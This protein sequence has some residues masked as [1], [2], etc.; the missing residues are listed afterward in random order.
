MDHLDSYTGRQ[1]IVGNQLVDIGTI[2]LQQCFGLFDAPQKAVTHVQLFVLIDT[3]DAGTPVPLVH[4]CNISQVV[5]APATVHDLH[6]FQII[7]GFLPLL[8]L[9]LFF[10]CFVTNDDIV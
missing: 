8:L 2:P 4:R 9:L 5:Q 7:D 6:R 3:Y 1:V 10:G